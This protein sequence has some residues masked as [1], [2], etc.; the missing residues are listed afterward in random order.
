MAAGVIAAS[1]VGAGALG[2]AGNILG[3]SANAD[4]QAQAAAIQAQQFAE[5]KKALQQSKQEALGYYQPYATVGQG[6]LN[7]LAYGMGIPTQQAI[8][9][10]DIPTDKKVGV[11]VDP[12]WNYVLQ[13]YQ[14]GGGKIK[15][16]LTDAK[17]AGLLKQ[18]QDQYIT[19]AQGRNV[20]AE[21]A[22]AASGLDQGS[23]FNYGLDQY[24]KIGRAHV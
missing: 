9:P 20:A 1:V 5:T 17:N 12:I 16:K 23:L 11:S 2:A 7:A 8:N 3:A 18:L 14:S 13:Q 19:L 21:Q 6:A 24:K 22:G 10:W 4:A 15:G